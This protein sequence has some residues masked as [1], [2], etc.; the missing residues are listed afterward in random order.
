M[1]TTALTALAACG[2]RLRDVRGVESKITKIELVGVERFDKDEL[3]GYL[4]IGESPILPWRPT[5]PF[6]EALLPIDAERIV[7]LYSAVGYYDAEVLSMVPD[8]TLGRVRRTGKRKG[9]RRLGKTTIQIRVREGEPTPIRSLDVRWPGAQGN[10]ARR[11]LSEAEVATAA[12]QKVGSPFEIEAFSAGSLNLRQALRER[13][14]AFAEVD[15]AAEVTLGE[16]VDVDYSLRPGPTVTIDE[17][18]IDG[19][20]RVPER[21]VRAEIDFLEGR[22]YSPALMK[23]VENAIYAMGVFQSVTVEVVEPTTTDADGKVVADVRIAVAEAPTQSVKV[24]PG[25]GIDPVRWEQRAQLRYR[26]RNVG[27][28]LTRFELNALAG[29]AELP[30]LYRPE[31]HGPLLDLEPSFTQKG[32]LE[33]RTTWRLA[34]H[35]ELGIWEGYQFYSPELR[36]GP[37]R[38]FTK[39]LELGV[40]YNLRF[41]D[42]FNIDPALNSDNSILGRDFRDPYLISYFEPRATVYLVDS[43]LKPQNGAILSAVYDIAGAGGDFAFH[44]IQPA[45]RAYYTP[46]KRVTLAARASVGFIFPIGDER[47]G[48]PIDM[49]FYLGGADTVRGWGMRRLAPKVL[50]GDC[51]MVSA[52]CRGIPVGGQS[53]FFSNAEVRV[54]LVKNVRGVAFFD[55]GDVREGV[56]TI[57]P[58]NWAMSAG[59][60]LRYVSPIGTFRLDAGIRLNETDRSLGERGWAI[61][62]GLGEAF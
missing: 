9:Q 40:T 32:F 24:G 56:R 4:N 52:D 29:Y 38:F 44:K 31:T 22:A 51:T 39:Y 48:A 28:N 16:G 54:E 5:A 8:T 60:G 36:M 53:M 10:A 1:L 46:H 14:H 45:V 2:G 41:V 37:Q 21:Y 18:T 30:A 50:T 19:L 20:D 25:L 27:S 47:G 7:E 15:E 12:G 35:F 49:N 43:I 42:F 23:Q 55:V 26:H 62:L 3:L 6:I 61:H 11:P 58:E 33:K 34:P 57:T 17:V 13:G 59:P